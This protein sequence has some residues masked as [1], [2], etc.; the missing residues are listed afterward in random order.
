M[1]DSGNQIILTHEELLSGL[2][3][4]VQYTNSELYQE[5]FVVETSNEPEEVKHNLDNLV[6]IFKG[7]IINV[8]E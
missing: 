3:A 6:H 8:D 7:G 4:V 2:L 1:V 5:E